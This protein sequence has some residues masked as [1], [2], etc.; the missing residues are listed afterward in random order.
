MGT[1]KLG[2]KNSDTPVIKSFNTFGIALER[3]LYWHKADEMGNEVLV[4]VFDNKEKLILRE[5]DQI[6]EAVRFLEA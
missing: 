2:G 6:Q 4:V 3:M 5:A 1:P